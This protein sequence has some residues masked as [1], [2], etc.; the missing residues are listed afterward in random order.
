MT[1]EQNVTWVVIFSVLLLIVFRLFQRF[2]YNTIFVHVIISF[3]APALFY[4]FAYSRNN[5]ESIGSSYWDTLYSL[6]S[7]WVIYSSLCFITFLFMAIGSSRRPA[8][9][10]AITIIRNGISQ[11]L[12]SNLLLALILTL[13]IVLTIIL[14]SGGMRYG[15]GL[16]VGLSNEALRP[17]L[18]LWQ[19]WTTFSIL[20]AMGFAYYKKTAS[21]LI[22]AVLVLAMGGLS[23]QRAVLFFPIIVILFIALNYNNV[24]FSL[25]PLVF[26]LFAV[27]IAVK[28]QDYRLEVGLGE[29][30]VTAEA[31]ILDSIAY[32][33]QF[34]E[35]RDFAWLLANYRGDLLLGKSYVSGYSSFIPSGLL[36]G[37]R[38]WNFGRWTA[39]QAGLDS[40]Y[41]PG[42]RGGVYAE[43]YFNF[44]YIPSAFVAALCGYI[45]GII[46]GWEAQFQKSHS[47]QLRVTVGL[48]AYVA[49]LFVL[50]TVS[51]VNFFYVFIIFGFFLLISTLPYRRSPKN[52][53]RLPF[54]TR[55]KQ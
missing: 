27:P 12:N 15:A 23:G 26:L 52:G 16:T 29:R 19:V 46:M 51:S 3:I 53:H 10:W 20:I 24:K 39:V 49:G 32:G 13:H 48:T 7:A 45:L 54:T 17:V 25:K 50:N 11:T 40:R 22:I 5:V 37:R 35:V 38:E 47:R 42:L 14:L 21:A 43:A 33:N 2:G 55:A 41:H 4:P 9:I 31:S 6:P 1:I 8:N 30:S 44:G 34:A 36:P 18:N 28:M